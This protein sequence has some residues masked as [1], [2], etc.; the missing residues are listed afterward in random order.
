[1]ASKQEEGGGLDWPATSIE[2]T[3]TYLSSIDRAILA[4]NSG[5]HKHPLQTSGRA[6][7]PPFFR[8]FF[9]RRLH[10]ARH[11][12]RGERGSDGSGKIPSSE[13]HWRLLLCCL[14]H[15]LIHRSTDRST[16]RIRTIMMDWFMCSIN[17]WSSSIPTPTTTGGSTH[18]RTHH[19]LLPHLIFTL[20]LG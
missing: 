12:T 1:M 13:A 11:T 20:P 7:F 17:P 5:G 4:S 19:R 3:P 18:H 14:G 9:A 8:L 15:H 16:H 2:Y 6:S 10:S